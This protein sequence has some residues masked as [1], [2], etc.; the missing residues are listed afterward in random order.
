MAEIQVFQTRPFNAT[1]WAARIISLLPG[2]AIILAP[3]GFAIYSYFRT[4]KVEFL[5]PFVAMAI[6]GLPPL[7]I[8]IAAWKWPRVGGILLIVMAAFFLSFAW[9]P[10]ND[11]LDPIYGSFLGAASLIGGVLHLI[12]SSWG[13]WLWHKSNK[14]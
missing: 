9:S 4:G 11:M 1:R 5:G 6:Y 3:W 12:V 2:A 10:A 13:R 7:V 14:A 8:G